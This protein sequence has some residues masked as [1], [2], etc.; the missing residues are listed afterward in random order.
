[1]SARYA[2]YYTPPAEDVLTRRAAAWL[3]RDAFTGAPL[4]RPSLP[5][6]AGLDLGTLTEDPRFYGFHATLK[7]PF[8]LGPAVDEAGLLDFAEGFAARQ[9]PF[10][11][12][13]APAALGRFLAFRPA[14]PSPGI[15]ALH[16]ACVR[17]FDPFRAPLGDADLAR[18]RKSP[19]T[20][21]Q[22]AKLLAWGYPYVF[23][24]FRFHM[25]L[26]SSIA[27][28]ATRERLLA[29]LQAHFADISAR[30][31]FSGVAV[32][33][34]AERAAPFQVL[35]RFDFLAQVTDTAVAG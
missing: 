13:I 19:L 14:C 34:Q 23:D 21:E 20:A 24:D 12:E 8:E 10:V 3:G 2:I 25:T 31:R 5:G 17:E 6:L 4:T 22:D 9:A 26:T 7:A 33:R 32:F 1:M 11:A 16:D 18:R 29:A 28:Q 27:D 15:Q 35:A 30:H